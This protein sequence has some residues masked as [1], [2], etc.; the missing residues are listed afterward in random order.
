M[1]KGKEARFRL[2]SLQL[3]KPGLIELLFKRSLIVGR[4]D[5]LFHIGLWGN[6]ITGLI[7]E[8]AYMANGVADYFASEGGL[9][10][11]VHGITG[12]LILV[13]GIGF[14]VR[15]VKNPFFRIAYGRVFFLDLGLLGA[16]AVSGTLHALPVFGF[17]PVSSFLPFTPGF[18]Q[19]LPAGLTAVVFYYIRG[20]GTI[21]V[22]FVYLFL[23]VSFLAGGAVRHA[24]ATIAWRLTKADS[25]PTMGQQWQTAMV[26]KDACGKCGRCVEV[27]PTFEA[28]NG[29][30]MEAPVVK[31]R[32][33]YQ[34][35]RSRK[36]TPSEIRYVS[37]QMAVC[38]QCNL[39]SGVC[40]FSF[41]FVPMYQ[42]MLAH[43]LKMAGQMN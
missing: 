43:A 13:G 28:F 42:D 7:M 17:T 26:F 24:V 11:W 34:I 9:L 38:A 16:L 1:A 40:P 14:I 39:C 3:K 12:L 22:L 32:K 15:Y 27:C 29:D 2:S 19:A 20:A 30:K 37:E 25:M 4:S 31:L 18:V 5:F 33:Y 10:S 8:T 35:H 36:L 41:N 6:I 21:H 23:A